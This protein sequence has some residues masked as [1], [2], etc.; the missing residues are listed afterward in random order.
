MRG[1]SLSVFVCVCKGDYDALLEWPFKHK[2]KFTLIDQNPE[3]TK[4]RNIS[5]VVQPNI[6]KENMSFLG[7]PKLERNSSFGAQKFV[8]LELLPTRYYTKDD[9]VFIKVDVDSKHMILL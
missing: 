2:I 5:H 4:R 1:K 8:E 7:R 6:C 3:E 9:C